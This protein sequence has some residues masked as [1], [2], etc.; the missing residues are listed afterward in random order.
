MT[1]VEAI[2]QILQKNKGNKTTILAC[3]P[4]NSA[5]DL[6]AERLSKFLSK[7]ELFRF[8]APSRHIEQVPDALREYVYR[9]KGVF[10]LPEQIRS[11]R[12]VVSTCVSSSVFH[13][14][15]MNCGNFDYIF[16]DEAGQATEPEVMIP[17]KTMAGDGTRIVLAG[18]HLQLGPVVRSDVARAMG[19]EMS[20][21]ERLM[22]REPYKDNQNRGI[23]QVFY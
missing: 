15:G 9:P 8:Y 20:Y 11:Y 19:L 17:I 5:A 10:S 6:I 3:A 18:D 12:V 7:S 22:D 1:L 21:L 23:R 14:T 4:S 13:G 16:V 2:R